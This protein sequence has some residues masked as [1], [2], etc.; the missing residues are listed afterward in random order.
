MAIVP[1]M[2]EIRK[3]YSWV[4]K[5]QLQSLILQFYPWA[6]C[7]SSCHFSP[8]SFLLVSFFFFV[9]IFL[10]QILG[11]KEGSSFLHHS[12]AAFLYGR[13]KSYDQPRQYIKKQRHFFAHKVPSS[14]S[15]GFSSS[16][17][18]M[19]EL[20]H[21][22]S[23]MPKNWCFWTVV[24]EKNLESPLDYKEIKPVNLKGNQ[25]WTFIGRT[26]TE[27]E[28]PIL[29]P[30]DAKNWLIGKDPDAGWDWRQEEKGMTKGEMIGWHYWLNGHEFEQALGVGDGQGI[31]V[32]CSP[33]HQ[34]S[35]MTEL[36]WTELIYTQKCPLRK[37]FIL[38]YSLREFEWTINKHRRAWKIIYSLIHQI[39]CEY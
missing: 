7:S 39:F 29:W 15:Y 30:P 36:N 6:I 14:Q 34:E 10:N 22:E 17:V 18:W 25:S 38:Y 20:D 31:L 19:W 23:W 16:H 1:G 26:D 12:C 32:Y 5:H 27:A 4:S 33:G 8:F 35:N 11:R 37:G 13:E 21:K 2:G 3:R 9:F 28:T 24:L